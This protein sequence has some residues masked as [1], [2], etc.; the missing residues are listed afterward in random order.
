[1]KDPMDPDLRDYYVAL[2]DKEHDL[3]LW[4]AYWWVL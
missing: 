2:A 1:M 4:K 3:D